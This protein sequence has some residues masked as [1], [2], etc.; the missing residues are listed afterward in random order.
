M[1]S[2]RKPKVAGLVLAAGKGTRMQSPLPKVL[3]EV[4]GV[5]MVERVIRVLQ[6]ADCDDVCLVIGGDL[7]YF[8]PLVARFPLTK[9]CVQEERRGTGDAVASLAPLLSK[10]PKVPFLKARALQGEPIDAT[11]ILVCAGDTP[12]LKT[13]IMRDFLDKS[14]AA[15]ADLAVL[16]MNHSNPTGYGRIKKGPNQSV[17]GIIEHKDASEAERAIRL[18]NSGVIFAQVDALF[19]C[20][21]DLKPNNSQGEYYLTDCFHIAKDKKLQTFVYETDDYRSFDGINDRQQLEQMN[22]W[23][24]SE[25]IAALNNAGVTFRQPQTTY[26]EPEVS[27]GPQ[28]VIEGQVS[29]AGE[30]QIGANCHIGTGASLRQVSLA[31]GTK[32]GAFTILKSLN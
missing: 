13:S 30:S 22:Q 7:A 4:C 14:I 23:M 6:G 26:I 9:I 17:A 1:V 20:L 28:T 5:P 31:D 2:S 21:A 12:A 29:L 15:G 16:G 19:N 24:I 18:C 3:H 27:V 11:H 8:A 25:K 10:A 32:V